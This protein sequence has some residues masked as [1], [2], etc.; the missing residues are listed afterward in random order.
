MVVEERLT[1]TIR[2]KR[3]MQPQKVDTNN[4]REKSHATTKSGHQQ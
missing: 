4:K 3:A 2:E 1:P